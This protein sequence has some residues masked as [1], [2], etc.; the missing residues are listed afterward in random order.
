MQIQAVDLRDFVQNSGDTFLDTKGAKA[1][2][3]MLQAP[4]GGGE[5]A[6]WK[7]SCSFFS[8]R[9]CGVHA[10][11]GGAHGAWFFRRDEQETV[12]AVLEKSLVFLTATNIE[13]VRSGAHGPIAHGTANLYLGSMGAS[14]LGKRT[15]SHGYS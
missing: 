4:G 10:Q 1:M 11:E 7:G 9:P 13:Q 3:D 12:L 6:V 2:A 14:L 15:P 8:R 5:Q